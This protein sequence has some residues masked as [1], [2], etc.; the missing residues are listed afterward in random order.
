MLWK[1]ES[2]SS[3]AMYIDL[4]RGHKT[5]EVQY[6]LHKLSKMEQN[7]L[8][9]Y[10]KNDGNAD[11]L[12]KHGNQLFDRCSFA[13][14]MKFYNESLCYAKIESKTLGLAYANRANCFLKLKM[15]KK[16]LADIELAL[17][18]HYPEHQA[19]KLEARK[20][21]CLK[22]MEIEDD[23]SDSNAAELDFEANEQYPCLA[24]VVT[25]QKND[26]IGHHLVATAD[27]EVGKTVMIEQCYVGVTKNDHYKLCNVCLKENQNLIPCKKCTSALF[28][29]DCK[30]TNLHDIECD[31]NFGCPAGFKFM[32]VVRSISLAKNAFGSAEELIAFV[33]NILQSDAIEA[34]NLADKQSV[35]RAFFQSYPKWQTAG[36]YL[37][38]AFLFHRLL[39]E[40]NEMKAFFRTAAHQRFLMHLVQHHILMILR[41]AFNKRIAPIGGVNITDT[42]VNIIATHLHHSCVPNVCH[43]LNNGSIRCVVIR[44]IRKGEQLSISYVTLHDFDSN[45]QRQYVLKQR[46]VNCCCKRCQLKS[47]SHSKKKANPNFVH[48]ERI[49]NKEKLYRGY[50]DRKQID[51]MKEKCFD[52]LNKYGQMES[53]REMDHIID[54]LYLLLSEF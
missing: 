4:F 32:D 38:Q 46:Y 50:F 1:K 23:Q 14:A 37:Q 42:Y 45:V 26:E 36:L 7:S 30:N 29:A 24:N 39:I 17:A 33:E 34:I 5:V 22:L 2:N 54:V 40:Q 31:M 48:I 20:M 8:G 21:E 41:G 49:F 51:V 3:D 13:K 52:F 43:I 11:K 53:C 28:C 18:N 10:Y 44:P 6:C 47:P 9:V 25:M 15:F 12:R 35:Y 16:C 19:K 27:I